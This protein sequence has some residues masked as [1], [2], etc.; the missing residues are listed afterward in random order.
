[1][2][3]AILAQI[4]GQVT[5]KVFERAFELWAAEYNEKPETFSD[6]IGEPKSY[7]ERAT[8]TFVE[9]LTKAEQQI[10]AEG[11]SL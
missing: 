9:Y 1:M 3:G 7:G 10:A 5:K 8:R 6:E 4:E 2:F 11:V